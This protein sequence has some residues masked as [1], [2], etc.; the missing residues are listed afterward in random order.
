MCLVEQKQQWLLLL[1][2][3]SWTVGHVCPLLQPNA[4]SFCL[5]LR[6]CTRLAWAVPGWS[7]PFVL[8]HRAGGLHS[9]G[10]CGSPYAQLGLARAPWQGRVG[11]PCSRLPAAQLCPRSPARRA[12]GQLP[13]LP[14]VT[15]MSLEQ[16]TPHPQGCWAPEV[17]LSWVHRAN[18]DVFSCFSE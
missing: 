10:R 1:C 8:G 6:P 3:A 11:F 18:S 12:V 17:G 15:V 13:V 2:D 5:L 4:G 16:V 9:S 7:V 14:A